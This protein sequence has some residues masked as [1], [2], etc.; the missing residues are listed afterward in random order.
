MGAINMAQA[1]ALDR[2]LHHERSLPMH[3]VPSVSHK[4]VVAIAV[5]LVSFIS[6]DPYYFWGR[7]QLSFV[8][9]VSYLALLLVG[10]QGGMSLHRLPLASICGALTAIF[11]WLSGASLGG[12]MAFGVAIFLIVSLNEYY[13]IGSA[14]AFRTLLAVSLTPA[15]VLWCLHL[16]LG[17]EVLRLANIAPDIIP[18]QLKV[19]EGV[20]Y[21]Q[22]PFAVV[23]DYMLNSTF[24]RICGPFDE[25]GVVGTVTALMLVADRYR[26]RTSVTNVI[27]VI[28]GILS[29]S[30]SFILIT[31]IYLF[32]VGVRNWRY[33]LLLMLTVLLGAV[34]VASN[35]QLTSYIGDRLEI[36][37][38]G[39]SGNNRSSGQTNSVYEVWTAGNIK[40]I[41]I[42]SERLADEIKDDGTSTWKITFI[43][44][45][46]FGVA[47]LFF[48]FILNIYKYHFRF[49]I[50]RYAFVIVFALSFL[51]RP[52]VLAA[53][54]I[55]I[56]LYAISPYD[57]IRDSY[58]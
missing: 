47:A 44:S 24:Y 15:I 26:L 33:G 49:D 45:G 52:D 21:A 27:F 6:L 25:P 17:D 28:A 39:L 36:N 30:L 20:G 5:A 48:V 43:R 4:R 42:G 9:A 58:S 16:I 1:E 32:I 31:L 29:F 12:G 55:L 35:T 53:A 18:N 11:Y 50:Y 10:R 2:K 7:F 3:K 46:L 56:F 57:K 34:V 37:Q 38:S 8:V 51:Q 40:E 14:R 22:Y 13:L 23:L 19:A 41:F 54:F